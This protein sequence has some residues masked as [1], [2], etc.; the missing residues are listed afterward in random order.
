MTLGISL[1]KS[2]RFFHSF[3]PSRS[4]QRDITEIRFKN[5]PGDVDT[6]NQVFRFSLFIGEDFKTTW[7]IVNIDAIVFQNQFRF[8]AGIQT[9]TFFEESALPT[10]LSL[11]DKF[12]QFSQTAVDHRRGDFTLM[13]FKKACTSGCC[14]ISLR[15]VS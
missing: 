15:I 7:N 8:I 10:I 4:F 3:N 2:F 5:F 12:I 6:L 14:K 1:D 11:G 9:I 13:T